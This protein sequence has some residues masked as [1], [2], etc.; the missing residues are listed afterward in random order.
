MAITGYTD[1]TGNAVENIELAKQRALAVRAALIR[2]GVAETQIQMSPRCR[3]ELRA[4]VRIRMPGGSMFH[5]W[6]EGKRPHARMWSASTASRS[7]FLECRHAPATAAR[8]VGKGSE[9]TPRG[10]SKW[11]RRGA[12][13]RFGAHPVTAR[14]RHP[15]P[16]FVNI[17]VAPPYAA[18]CNGARAWDGSLTGFNQTSPMGCQSRVAPLQRPT[19]PL[20]R[21]PWD[22]QTAARSDAGLKL[23]TTAKPG[24]QPL[25]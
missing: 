16:V 7:R 9:G 4:A 20:S 17:H 24:I 12:A 11:T 10:E 25:G 1:R 2:A 23:V 21:Q 15:P 14:S 13:P 18:F 8:Y 6:I 19:P 22:S 3:L 5:R